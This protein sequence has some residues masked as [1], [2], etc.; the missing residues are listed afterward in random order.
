MTAAAP[1]LPAG[2][3]YR[4][5]GPCVS[6]SAPVTV[7]DDALHLPLLCRECARRMLGV[8]IVFA[9]ALLLFVFGVVAYF[10]TVAP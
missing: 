8:E 5:H 3:H 6:C 7:K 2:A 9:G 1:K 4:R 10:A